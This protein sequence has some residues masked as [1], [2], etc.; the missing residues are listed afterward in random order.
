[1][2][3]PRDDKRFDFATRA[4]EQKGRAEAHRLQ[5]ELATD[6]AMKALHTGAAATYE[7]IANDID[8]TAKRIADI[9]RA[10]AR[11][12]TRIQQQTQAQLSPDPIENMVE[13]QDPDRTSEK[14]IPMPGPARSPT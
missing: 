5:A 4:F 9:D 8:R 1:M 6:P 12:R 11:V 7:A 10:T 14:A 13:P 2:T 3:D